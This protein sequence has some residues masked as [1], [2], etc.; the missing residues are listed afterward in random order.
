MEFGIATS[1]GTVAK[2]TRLLA[3]IITMAMPKHE[4]GASAQRTVPT[5]IHT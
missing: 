5:D 3:S 4:A 2:Q 1:Y